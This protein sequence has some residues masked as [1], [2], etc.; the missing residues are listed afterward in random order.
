[1]KHMP[2]MRTP[3]AQIGVKEECYIHA[4]LDRPDI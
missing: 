3:Y 2:H 1:M 4:Y